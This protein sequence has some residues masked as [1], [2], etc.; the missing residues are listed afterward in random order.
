MIRVYAY[1]VFL[2]VLSG[3]DPAS[4]DELQKMWAEAVVD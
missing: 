1:L 4:E 3:S 2:A